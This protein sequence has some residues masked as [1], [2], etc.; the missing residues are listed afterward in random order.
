MKKYKKEVGWVTNNYV[1]LRAIIEFIFD[2]ID[3]CSMKMLK[4]YKYSYNTYASNITRNSYS[5]CTYAIMSGK[6][7][8]INEIIFT[9]DLILV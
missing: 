3:N 2:T 4:S 9:I 5:P 7:V 6:D 8:S 1:L